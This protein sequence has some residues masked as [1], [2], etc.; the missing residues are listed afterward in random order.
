MGK[1]LIT[2]PDGKKYRVEGETAEGAVAALKKSLGGQTPPAAKSPQMTDG[3]SDMSAMTQGTYAPDRGAA[4]YDNIFGD[5]NDGVDSYGEQ[6][7]RGL[8]DMGKAAMAGLGRGTADLAGMAGQGLPPVIAANAAAQMMGQPAP[9][10][11]ENLREGL[12][13]ATGGASDYRGETTAGRM[14]GTVGEFIPGTVALGGGGA[15]NLMRYAVLP[16]MASEGAGMLTEGTAME[17]PA[18]IAGAIA[19]AT[20]PG[21]LAKGATKLISPS[22]G[23]DPERLK[24]AK[25]L[26]DFGVPIT[27][28]QRVGSEAMR[29]KEGLTSRGQAVGEAQREA[30]TK[31]ALGTAG[32]DA[33]RATPE[34]LA[35]TAKRIGAVFDDV[36]KGVDVTPDPQSVKALAGAVDTYKS[37]APTGN[38]APIV[39]E[40]FKAVTKAFRGGNSV[41]ATTVNT[42][43]SRLS[44][45]TTS[46]DAAT[47]DAATAALEAVDDML[48][49]ALTAL[50]RA[51]DVARLATARGQWRNFLAIQK[52]ATSAGENAAAGLLSP[53]ALRNAIVQ[54]GRAAFGQG[55]RGDIGDLARAGEGV[56][57]A[58]P[59]SGTPGG[60]AAR[61]ITPQNVFAALGAGAGASTGNPYIAM[62]GAGIGAA[63]PALAGAVRM[64]G[65]VQAYLANQFM[66]AGPKVFPRNA[67]AP[68]GSAISTER[69]A[70]SAQ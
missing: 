52:A 30:F 25:V 3:L 44:K 2:G 70:L 66:G 38:Q 16:G 13:A 15:A 32:T 60:L 49:G 31:A 68:I 19:A 69:N 61:G 9:V 34:V 63:V 45:L 55:K 11:P 56:M 10:S 12:S 62:A 29:R 17:G 7:G 28:G 6:I 37:L 21:M 23:A 14:A 64:S 26:D 40:V 33:T 53:S 36:V 35:E 51:D 43:R 46:T 50:D 65:P 67:L 22:G 57:K 24:L 58:L 41:P 54:Q 39:S 42:W 20:L 47:R 18:R 1:F 5:P 27:A 4:L 48:T 8:N 59:D